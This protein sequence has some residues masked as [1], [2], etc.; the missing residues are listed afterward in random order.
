VPELASYL[1]RLE[2]DRPLI[3][4]NLAVFPILPRGVQSPGGSW[5]TLD[6]ALASGVLAVTEKEGGGSVPVI[7]VA[8][9]SRDAYVFAMAG[10]VLSGGK[11]TRTVRQDF[12]LAPGQAVHVGV[13][14]VEAHRWSGGEGLTSSGFLVPQSIH[15]ELRRGTSQQDVWEEVAGSNAA[16]GTENAT[17][18]LEVGLKAGPVRDRLDEVR[19]AIVPGVPAHAVGFIFMCGS[20][21]LGAEMFGRPGLARALLPKLI[22]AYAVDVTVK[23]RGDH[24]TPPP[25]NLAQARAFLDR[26]RQVGSVRTGTPG[27]GAGI[28]T[29]ADGLVGDGVSLGGAVVHYG[30]QVSERIVPVPRP[31]PVRPSVRPHISEETR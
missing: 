26:I 9:G 27:S 29:N 30:C 5:L 6:Q 15:K 28:R 13:Y 7:H 16:L 19:K 18:S 31:R 23:L 25:G 17:G 3:Y 20:R 14:C 2:V 22:D 10:E 8:N 11:Q 4:R 1:S 12:V 24:P 21:P